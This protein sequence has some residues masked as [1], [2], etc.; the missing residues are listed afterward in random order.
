MDVP[1]D[2]D[3]T[4]ALL[5]ALDLQIAWGADE[6]LE[7]APQD[8]TRPRAVLADPVS[9]PAAP[10]PRP[11]GPATRPAPAGG[12]VAAF[13]PAAAR[14]GDLAAGADSLEALR[15]AI[16]ALDSPLKD[17]ASKLV[18]ADGVPE[19]GLMLIGE[20]P[21][22]DEDRQGLPF[23]GVSGRLLDR[24]FESIGVRRAENAYL[25]N[26]LP[27][28]PPGNRTPTD[29]EINLF[30]PFVLRHIAIVRPRHLVFLGGTA[31][32]A[33]LRSREGITRLRGRWH[34]LDVPGLGPVPVLATLHPAYLLRQPSAK[35][36]AWADLRLLRRSLDRA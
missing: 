23:V 6:A 36:E 29:A 35:R 1:P 20:A 28:R 17:T 16:A 15:E 14:A 27:W 33:L 8:R 25:T 22:A 21:G 2:P 34:S 13:A 9:V 4:A 11:V 3:E 32:K 31:A 24:M 12:A 26:I 19:S 10:A 7:E 30:T 5:A 18:F